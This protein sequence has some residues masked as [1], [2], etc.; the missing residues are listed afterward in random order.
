MR[1]S[2]CRLP[3]WRPCSLEKI[4]TCLHTL[5]MAPQ[6]ARPA[7][8]P[9]P[10]GDADDSVGW[11]VRPFRARCRVPQDE[12]A[13]LPVGRAAKPGTAGGLAPANISGASASAAPRGMSPASRTASPVLPAH[14]SL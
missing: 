8:F 5:W 14:L 13:Q 6:W 10:K 7:R 2:W 4:A 12:V 3:D 1:M 11:V 9:G